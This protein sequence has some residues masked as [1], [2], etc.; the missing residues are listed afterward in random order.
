[1]LDPRAPPRESIA[2]RLALAA[3]G[4][5]LSVILAPLGCG[6]ETSAPPDAGTSP[7]AGAR[8]TSGLPYARGLHAF[9]PG[10]GAGYGADRLPAVVLGPPSGSGPS[11]GSLDVVSLGVGGEIVLDLAPFLAFDGPG[12]DLIVFENAF[13]AAGDP[14]QPFAEL[15]EVSTSTDAITWHAFPCVPTRD[16]RTRWPGCAGWTP[17]LSFDPFEVVPLDPARTG[18]DAFDLATTGVRAARFVRVRDLSVEG[19]APSAGFDLDAIGVVH[20]ASAA[21]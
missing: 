20:T 10:E 16:G 11:A 5:V 3:A 8:D 13:F 2:V 15:G 1:M 21:R 9:A 19:A 14:A 4:L 17:T 6:G 7:D 18:G 12:P